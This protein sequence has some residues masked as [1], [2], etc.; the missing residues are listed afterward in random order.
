MSSSSRWKLAVAIVLGVGIPIAISDTVR[1]VLFSA[2]ALFVY[3]NPSEKDVLDA[4]ALRNAVIA[5]HSF[6]Q[7]SASEPGEPPVFFRTGS[8][9]LLTN[10]TV[11]KVY[12][13]TD[14]SQQDKI[15]EVVKGVVVARRSKPVDLCFYDHENWVVNQNV[16]LRGPEKLLRRTR[17]H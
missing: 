11:L 10:P 16:A 15:I 9:M 5:T 13:V 14:A 12:E 3:G 8:Q 6:P 1:F 2:I 7:E 4:Q 17:V